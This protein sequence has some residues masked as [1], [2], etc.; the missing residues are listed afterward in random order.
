MISWRLLAFPL[1]FLRDFDTHA[2]RQPLNRLAEIEPFVIHHKA[3]RIAAG[4]T[5]KAVIELALGV[6]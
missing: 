5:A 1:I 6:Y 2:P 3:Q 4:T